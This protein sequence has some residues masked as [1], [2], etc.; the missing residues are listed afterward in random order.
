MKVQEQTRIEGISEEEDQR[1]VHTHHDSL[2]S[3]QNQKIL[4]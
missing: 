4:G 3:A 1:Q 2:I